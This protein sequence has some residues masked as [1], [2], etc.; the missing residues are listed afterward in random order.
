MAYNDPFGSLNLN[1]DDLDTLDDIAGKY[2]EFLLSHK[3]KH[4][5]CIVHPYF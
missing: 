5:Y 4:I 2:K 3:L 1:H